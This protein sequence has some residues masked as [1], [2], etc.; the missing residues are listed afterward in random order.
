MSDIFAPPSKEELDGAMFAP[1]TPDELQPRDRRTLSPVESAISG[2]AQAV[3]FGF[4]DEIGGGLRA[5]AGA[6]SGEGDF[7][8]LYEKY[9]DEQRAHADAAN[10]DNPGS[11]LAGQVG[12]AFANPS[13]S[14]A[15]GAAAVGALI[16]AG[17]SKNNPIESYD[18]A[19]SFVADVGLGAGVGA[20]AQGSINKIG[21]FFQNLKPQALKKFAEEK[22]VKSA[23][24]MT[25]EFRELQ[26]SGRL[27]DLGREILDN[28]IIRV[29]GGLDEVSQKAGDIK[30][31]AG[32]AIGSTVKRADDL[33]SKS[34]EMIDNGEMFGF[35]P[36]SGKAQ[37]K[38]FIDETFQA[39]Y[40]NVANRIRTEI[41][42]K[43]R[44]MG[45]YQN[46]VAKLDKLAD[47][48]EQ[49]GVRS[50]DDLRKQKTA[51]GK[52]TRFGSDTVPQ[53]FA[54]D[55]YGIFKTELENVMG[56][57]GNLDDA[58]SKK[59]GL[60]LEQILAKKLPGSS[61]ED[62][63]QLIQQAFNEANRA[64]ASTSTIKKM[65]DKRGGGLM[66]N[67]GIS[68]TD[69]IAAGSGF[70]SGD[71]FADSSTKGA[72]LLAL[73]QFI[74]KRGN[75]IQAI[76]ADKLYQV[77]SKAPNSLGQFGAAIEKAAE[78]SP[79]SLIMLHRSLMNRPDYQNILNNFEPEQRGLRLPQDRN[80]NRGISLPK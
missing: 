74:R 29:F 35:L 49:L 75:A 36:E 80:E 78:K 79:L 69:T 53:A 12:G 68:L 1:P 72:A 19:K 40:K 21:K 11:F 8:K 37:A 44:S 61:P 47:F 30:R 5:A 27:H 73:N 43:H 26:E 28:D 32:A 10:V 76:G 41:A 38:E 33:V 71:G 48:F 52:I 17:T 42:D 63:A 67:R 46:E 18:K 51:Q 24:A 66:A 13:V 2:A 39:N 55:V 15:K 25:K 58:I 23:G 45:A 4:A 57:I 70:A 31:R 59:T 77:L 6:L 50:I 54:K 22:A 20:V 64:F 56:R 60:S 9:R 62:R 14:T 3:S 34:K 7:S 65:A 16:G